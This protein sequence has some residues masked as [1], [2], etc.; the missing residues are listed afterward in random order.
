MIYSRQVLRETPFYREILEEGR[1]EGRA[2]ARQTLV[3]MA[4]RFAERRFGPNT[5]PVEEVNMIQDLEALKQLCF[6][7]EEFPDVA[8]LRQRILDL[9]ARENDSSRMD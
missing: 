8:A 1:V 7:M 9:A 3:D 4:I 2:E 6:E 5:A